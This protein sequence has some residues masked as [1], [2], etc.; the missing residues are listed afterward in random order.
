[1]PLDALVDPVCGIVRAVAPVEHPEGAPP[2][3]TAVTAEV[4]D[5]RRLGAWPADRVA[6][7]TTF[8]D[9]DGARTAAVAEAVERYCG[10][11]VPPPGHPGA[12]LRA[13]ARELA[14]RGL[15]LYGPDDVPRYADWQYARPGFPYR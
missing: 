12:P 5:A 11:R 6:L 15:R 8:G 4:S 1:M 2:R 13:T 3:Y 9:A 10:N 14:E 7:G